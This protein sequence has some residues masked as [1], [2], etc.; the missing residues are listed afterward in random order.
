MKYQTIQTISHSERTCFGARRS[1]ATV[2][3]VTRQY[4]DNEELCALQYWNKALFNLLVDR[5]GPLLYFLDILR[6]H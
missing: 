4:L 5:P 1:H 3:D 6:Q 2:K